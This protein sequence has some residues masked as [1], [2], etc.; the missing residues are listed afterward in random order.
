M[1]RCE[2]T[3][4]VSLDPMSANVS[5]QPQLLRWARERASLAPEQLA[6][7]VGLKEARVTQWETTGQL[8]LAHLERVASKTYTPVGFFFLP[9][10]PEE[11]LPIPDFR[12]LDGDRVKRPSP[13][14]LDNHLSVSAATQLVP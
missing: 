7:R 6:R 5:V 2:L 1:I 3:F 14:L 13:N 12:T 9:E 11:T 4:E 8:S 10:P